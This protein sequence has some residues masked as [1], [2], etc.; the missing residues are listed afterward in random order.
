MFFF[1]KVSSQLR[2][3]VSVVVQSP[4]TI[5]PHLEFNVF[6]TRLPPLVLGKRIHFY[7]VASSNVNISRTDGVSVTIIG[8]SSEGTGSEYKCIVPVNMKL[9]SCLECFCFIS[10]GFALR[11]WGLL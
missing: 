1:A 2:S 10:S 5:G 6:P 3:D 9:S 4:P 11:L 8:K 7:L